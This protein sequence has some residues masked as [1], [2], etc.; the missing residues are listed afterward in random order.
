MA[1]ECIRNLFCIFRQPPQHLNAPNAWA[2]SESEKILLS[3]QRRHIYEPLPFGDS[4]PSYASLTPRNTEASSA[5]CRSS[6]PSKGLQ[7]CPHEFMSFDRLQRIATLPHFQ[8]PGKYLSPLTS[9]S[10]MHCRG[11]GSSP[12]FEGDLA[13]CKPLG[14]LSDFE[15]FN[16]LNGCVKISHHVS[17]AGARSGLMLSA[18]WE[19]GFNRETGRKCYSPEA[20]QNFLKGADIWLCEHKAL[21]DAGVIDILFGMVNSSGKLAD[22]VDRYIAQEVG[23]NCDRCDSKIRL[24]KRQNSC[25]VHVERFLGK[26]ELSDDPFWVA[27]C[28]ARTTYRCESSGRTL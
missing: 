5:P 8:A 13:L 24:E 14:L 23:I 4:P 18:Y 11:I 3:V 27:Q 19:I 9:G 26:A 20:L 28:G 17:Q 6:T 7:I 15:M 2:L 22:P 16:Y 10:E 12:H 21:V 1:F 25:L